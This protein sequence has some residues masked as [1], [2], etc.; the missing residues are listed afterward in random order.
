MYKETPWTLEEKS[1]SRVKKSTY[2]KNR[3]SDEAISTARVLKLFEDNKE[4]RYTNNEIAKILGIS[5]GTVSAINNRLVALGDTKLTALGKKPNLFQVFQHANGSG[6]TVPL[7]Y[8]KEDASI[9]ILSIF[10]GNKNKTYTKQ[11]IAEVVACSEGMLTKSLQIL[12]VNRKIK[13]IGHTEDGKAMYQHAEGN[14]SGYEIYTEPDEDY[15]SLSV[16]LKNNS[17][18]K[19][20]ALFDKKLRNKKFRLFYSSTGLRKEFL[21]KDLDKI[22]ENLDK[23][24]ILDKLFN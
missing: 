7:L 8:T 9:S 22:T 18:K 13:L 11:D 15:M 6:V 12:L 24:G 3:E 21:L 14:K 1:K 19:Q 2:V 5:V 17:L 10:K 4:K 16:Y 23:K 20:K